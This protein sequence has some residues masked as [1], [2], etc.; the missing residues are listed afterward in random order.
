MT[1]AAAS[2]DVFQRVREYW[3]SIGTELLPPEP[4]EAIIAAFSQ[5]GRL[6]VSC[7]VIRLYRTVGGFHDR[8]Y[9]EEAWKLWSLKQVTEDSLKR[10]FVDFADFLIDSHRHCVRFT[11]EETSA[12]FFNPG[13]DF[14][15]D[16]RAPSLQAFFEGY[17]QAVSQGKLFGFLN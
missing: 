9:D 8:G 13:Y 6:P 1:D 2:P 10:D 3:L 17:L 16:M 12:V 14:D 11:S 15:P 5:N 7:D 4:E